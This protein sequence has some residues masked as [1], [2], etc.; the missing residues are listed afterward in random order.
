MS[1]LSWLRRYVCLLFRRYLIFSFIA[2]LFSHEL[3]FNVAEQLDEFR[4]YSGIVILF[5]VSFLIGKRGLLYSCYII[6]GFLAGMAAYGNFE[7]NLYAENIF[8]R[9]WIES[10]ICLFLLLSLLVYKVYMDYG[11]KKNVNDIV[12]PFDLY[13]ERR[14]VLENIM[15]YLDEHN[16]VAIDSPYGNGKTTIVNA[17]KS[18]KRDW[19][20][21]TIGILSTTVEN[22]ESCIIREINRVLESKGVF[23]NP[24]SRLKSFFSNEFAYCIGDLLFE[25][26]SYEDQIKNFVYDIRSLKKTIVL[27]FE[28]IDRIRDK[29]HLNKIFSICD[30]LLK[31]DKKYIKVIYQCNMKTLKEL[32]EEENYVEKYIPK[33]IKL[34]YLSSQVFHNVLAANMFRYKYIENMN[35]DFLNRYSYDKEIFNNYQ[36]PLSNCTVRIVEHILD[37]VNY[38]IFNFCI[39]KEMINAR[40]VFRYNVEFIVAYF[41]GKRLIPNVVELL[42]KDVEIENQKIFYC[43][44]KD[45]KGFMSSF[46]DMHNAQWAQIQK[47]FDVGL[48]NKA[49]ENKDAYLFMQLFGFSFDRQNDDCCPNDLF[50]NLLNC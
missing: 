40:Y 13:L 50:Q 5:F 47:Y 9:M 15:H 49:K 4:F 46:G 17:L 42:E 31:Y 28:D 3:V 24:I 38:F 10:S 14:P 36:F 11:I 33:V 35:F 37:D 48:C 6:I 39:R 12:D 44:D 29:D 20:F 16:V 23:S 25:S 2:F 30:S 43:F 19:E 26:Q 1:V 41:I 7:L 8:S 22:V 34:D 18:V 32:F 27:N 45:G 21:I